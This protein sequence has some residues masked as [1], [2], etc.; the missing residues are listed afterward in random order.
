MSADNVL[1][2]FTLLW[3]FTAVCQADEEI[4]LSCDDVTGSV[5]KEVTLSCSVSLPNADCCIDFF[6]YYEMYEGSVICMNWF[7]RDSCEHRNSFTCRYTP[8]TAMTE[9]FRFF[10]VTTCGVKGTEFTVDLSDPTKPEIDIEH[11]EI[12]VSC[13][14]VTGSVGK[15]VTLSCSVSLPNADCCIDFFKYY[16]M[17]E[18]SVI[19]MNW[20]LRDSCEHR[21]RFTCRYTPT[22][23]MTEQFRFFVVTTCGVKGTEFTVDLSALDT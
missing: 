17:Y 4:S 10:V 13:D 16:E 12:S 23:A 22:T 21:N 19:C 18:G 20:F 8:T 9:Q 1:L 6:K 7:L 14:D 11:P 2:L 15:E 5:G 3:T